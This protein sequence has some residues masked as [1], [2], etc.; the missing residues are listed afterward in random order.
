MTYSVDVI[1]EIRLIQTVRVDAL[2]REEAYKKVQEEMD[3]G[4]EKVLEIVSRKWDRLDE[5][6]Y[7]SVPPIEEE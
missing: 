1:K 2:S 4:P 6:T 3:R 5:S 7:C